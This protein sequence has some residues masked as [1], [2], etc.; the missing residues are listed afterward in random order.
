MS[1]WHN[2][3][4]STLYAVHKLYLFKRVDAGVTYWMLSDTLQAPTGNGYR[5]LAMA[6]K[7]KGILL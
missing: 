7:S 2:I 3:P 4:D 6:L 5:S 1:T